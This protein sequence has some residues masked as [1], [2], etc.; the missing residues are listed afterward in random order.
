[1]GF[2]GTFTCSKS[3]LRSMLENQAA[4]GPNGPGNQAPGRSASMLTKTV[5]R[6]RHSTKFRSPLYW[7]FGAEFEP[8][9]GGTDST[10]LRLTANAG[11]K[12]DNLF[13]AT[14]RPC[15]FTSH[16]H[17]H[18]GVPGGGPQAKMVNRNWRR[19]GGGSGSGSDRTPETRS[20]A[21]LA[22]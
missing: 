1:M 11:V 22:A 9:K 12:I 21:A 7:G 2:P 15:F 5:S 19:S 13:S 10:L 17:V 4:Y 14:C 6:G 18:A 16:T 8:L 3:R 20:K